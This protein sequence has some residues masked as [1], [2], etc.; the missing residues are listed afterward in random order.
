MKVLIIGTGGVGESAATIAK[1]R[2]PRGD[3]LQLC[4]MADYNLER[5]QR[6]SQ[7]L[8][9]ER[10]PAEQVNAADVDQMVALARKHG[11]DLVFNAVAPNFNQAIL[12]AALKAEVNYMDTAMTLSEPHLS[13]PFNQCGLKLGDEEFP[14]SPEFDRI[15][16]LAMAGCGVEPG[17]ADLFAR[18]GAD[19]FFDEVDEIG[20]RDG[21][22]LEI[23]GFSG[24]SFG[25]S[26]WTTI[27]EC[28]NPAI[29][30]E[31]GTGWHTVQPFS[32][33]EP[34]WL[35]EG[36]G[37]VE[38]AHVEHEEVICI[39]R[40]APRLKGVKKATFKYALGDEF[41]N[42]IEVFKAVNIDKKEKIK[43]GDCMVSPRDVVAAAAPDPLE[44]GK[45]YVGKTAA[46]T[47]IRGKKDGL[48]RE[49][50][51]YQVADNQECVEKYD[52]QVVQAQTA[53]TPVVLWEL[54]AAGKWAGYKGNPGS[55]VHVPEEFDADDYVALMSDYEFPGGVLEME[56]EYKIARDRGALLAAAR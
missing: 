34:F 5:A 37:T 6:F 35:P 44:I 49:V 24:I 45:R 20:I 12:R 10:F 16:R 26:I 50:Y 30:W 39:G 23:P 56:S 28:T 17:M 9:D 54:M 3:W 47:W 7:K 8:G 55:G 13:D 46:G 27:E 42:A 4:V 11:V 48:V 40:A 2:D 25:F 51:L 15:G 1:R 33:P 41:I 52:Q 38:V 21:S 19:H 22:N 14:L 53:F 31:D 36:I 29:V 32:D 43:V 18:Y